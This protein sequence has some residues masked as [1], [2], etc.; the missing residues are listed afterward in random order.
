MK[1]SPE[2]AFLL[3][4]L[5]AQQRVET[6]KASVLPVGWGGEMRREDC[7]GSVLLSDW[8]VN[9][10]QVTPVWSLY[11]L[12]RHVTVTDV[13]GATKTSCENALP[14]HACI[15]TLHFDTPFKCQLFITVPAFDTHTQWLTNRSILQKKKQ[16]K[17]TRKHTTQRRPWPPLPS[18]C[19]KR[20]FSPR[21]CAT[22]MSRLLGNGGCI[23]MRGREG[24]GDTSRPWSENKQ[25]SVSVRRRLRSQRLPHL[26]GRL[27]L[28]Q[29]SSFP[30][31][32]DRNTHTPPL[33]RKSGSVGLLIMWSRQGLPP[34]QP[35]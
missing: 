27:S 35:T 6:Q 7:G 26:S 34:H 31:Q 9:V 14:F 25:D 10:L 28:L 23:N 20:F 33:G 32:L 17:K 1:I 12:R 16:Q 29:P 11:Q 8:A 2:T 5:A 30:A 22:P 13:L 21:P 4:K 15:Y 24:A 18:P 3:G 19:H